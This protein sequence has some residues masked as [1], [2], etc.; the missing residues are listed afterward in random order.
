M[1]CTAL[2]LLPF[3]LVAGCA[4]SANEGPV[5]AWSADQPTYSLRYASELS[6]SMKAIGDDQ[7]HEN[8]LSGGSPARIDE[9]MKPDWDVVLIA[10]DASDKAGSI[11]RAAPQADA[12]AKSADDTISG[13][14]KDYDG[15]L[16]DT[17]AEKKK[18]G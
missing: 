14:Q 16:K 13:A 9:P 17:Y 12:V 10:I 1:R 3:V 2:A 5:F 11:D 4:S 18:G 15:A 7:T 6:A 8:T